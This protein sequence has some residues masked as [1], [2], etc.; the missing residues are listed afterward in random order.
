MKKCKLVFFVACCV[1]VG[2]CVGFLLASGLAA[3][4]LDPGHQASHRVFG[5][6]LVEGSMMFGAAS[7]GGVALIIWNRL[8]ITRHDTALRITIWAVSSIVIGYVV[9][10]LLET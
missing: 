9:C 10:V 8:G 7:A 6:L 3:V 1:L 4:L 2:M 5:R